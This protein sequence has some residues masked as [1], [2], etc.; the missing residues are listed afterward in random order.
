MHGEPQFAE[1]QYGKALWKI[2]RVGDQSRRIDNSPDIQTQTRGAE[3]IV[4]NQMSQEKSLLILRQTCG[5]SNAASY[6][7]NG[8]PQE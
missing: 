3:W 6:L 8:I 7:I 1:T 4:R 5:P 2:K